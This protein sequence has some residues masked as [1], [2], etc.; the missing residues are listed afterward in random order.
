MGGDMIAH[1]KVV[2]VSQAWMHA[3]VWQTDTDVVETHEREIVGDFADAIQGA[4]N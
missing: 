1:R 2:K 3:G 4:L